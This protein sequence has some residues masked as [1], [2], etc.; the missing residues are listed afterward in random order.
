VAASLR[1][2]LKKR[3][4][5]VGLTGLAVAVMFTGMIQIQHQ[6]I[7]YKTEEV[8]SLL[9]LPSGKYLKPLSLGYDQVVADL[10]WIKTINYFGNHFSTD[11]Q[12]PWLSH[13]LNLI[14]DLDPRFDFPYYFGGLVLSLETSQV[15]LA[16]Q[17]LE[18]G[19]EAYPQKWEFPYYI[20]FNHFYHNGDAARAVPYIEKA[21]SLP[22]APPFLK[23]LNAHLYL[24]SGQKEA[25]LAFYREVYRNTSDEMLRQKTKE[26]MDRILLDIESENAGNRDQTSH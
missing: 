5:S 14:I 2:R 4:L 13:L 6:M 1:E 24:K 17:V 21:A 25:A 8:E 9:Y 26:K 20:A 7:Q 11:K 16:N 19:I 18:R 23:R 22:K 15:E 10:L 12:Y 3:S